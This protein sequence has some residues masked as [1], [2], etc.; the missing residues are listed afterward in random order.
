M[1]N[2]LKYNGITYVRRGTVE[3][4]GQY[5][6]YYYTTNIEKTYNIIYEGQ[7]GTLTTDTLYYINDVFAEILRSSHSFHA[8]TF[9]ESHS[10]P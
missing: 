1:A 5:D 8:V 3:D 9:S 6:H 2:I 7:R 10:E 4:N